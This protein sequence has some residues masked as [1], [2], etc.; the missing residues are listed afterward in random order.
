MNRYG[1][2]GCAIALFGLLMTSST[3]IGAA[4][5]PAMEC[6]EST[7]GAF[8]LTSEVAPEGT[9]VYFY[10]CTE[11]GWILYGTSFCDNDG[12]CSSD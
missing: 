6:N 5:L 4:V 12:N 11:Y 1:K 2:M 7:Y 8:Q 3:G 9:Y 10:G